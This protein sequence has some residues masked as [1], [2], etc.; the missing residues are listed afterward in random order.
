MVVDDETS[1]LQSVYFCK[2]ECSYNH[3]LQLGNLDQEANSTDLNV[4]KQRYQQEISRLH[5]LLTISLIDII[6]KLRA[7]KDKKPFTTEITYLYLL[8]L[9]EHT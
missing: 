2:R 5:R 6:N 4:R 7:Y 9:K 3:S 8:Y 1:F